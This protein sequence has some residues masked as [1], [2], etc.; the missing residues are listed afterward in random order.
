MLLITTYGT[1]FA[2][3]VFIV[4]SEVSPVLVKRFWVM[5]DRT[6]AK[7]FYHSVQK[8]LPEGK[9]EKQWLLQSFL[10]YT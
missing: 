2:Q 5:I 4:S 10:R 6:Y 8:H 7:S 9:I 1:F 3:T